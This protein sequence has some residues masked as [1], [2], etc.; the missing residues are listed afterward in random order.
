MPERR[1]P[2]LL[3]PATRR[4]ADR[5][6][7]MAQPHK[8][9]SRFVARDPGLALVLSAFFF[10]A[11]QLYMDRVGW[12]MVFHFLNLGALAVIGLGAFFHNP[13]LAV[14]GAADLLAIRTAAVLHARHLVRTAPTVFHNRV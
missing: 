5:R 13:W 2:P 8:P 3:N 1:A 10:G 4:R 12:F 9:G 6:A 11:G 14:F 7:L